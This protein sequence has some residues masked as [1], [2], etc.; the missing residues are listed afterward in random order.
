MKQ[1]MIQI[2]QYLNS[3]NING[4]QNIVYMANAMGIIQQIIQEIEQKEG[5]ANGIVIDN[6]KKKEE[7]KWVPSMLSLPMI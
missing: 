2:F 7:N 1:R 3:I 6:T 5:D 4:Q